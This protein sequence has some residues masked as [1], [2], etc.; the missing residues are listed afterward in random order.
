MASQIVSPSSTVAAAASGS[1]EGT[2]R[3]SMDAALEAAWEMDALLALLL[4]EVGPGKVY[5]S[6]EAAQDAMRTRGLAMRM[7]DLTSVLMS[8]VGNDGHDPAPLEAKLYGREFI[9]AAIQDD[10]A[11]GSRNHG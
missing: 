1:K 2:P 5:D 7:R 8:V 3:R 4:R 10:G 6:P 11:V 9:N